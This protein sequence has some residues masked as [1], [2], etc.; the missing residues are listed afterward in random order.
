MDPMIRNKRIPWKNNKKII[1]IKKKSGIR[2]KPSDELLGQ[3]LIRIFI[4]PDFMESCTF[5]ESGGCDTR[6]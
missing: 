4:F 1:I 3:D 6:L 2:I 5:D